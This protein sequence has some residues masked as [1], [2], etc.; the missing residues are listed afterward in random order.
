MTLHDGHLCEHGFIQANSALRDGHL[1]ELG[2]IQANSALHDGHL[3]EL[4]LYKPTVPAGN[5][6]LEKPTSSLQSPPKKSKVAK[7]QQTSF[8]ISLISS[9]CVFGPMCVIAIHNHII[10]LI[11]NSWQTLISQSH[12]TGCAT[13]KLKVDSI[14]TMC[15][16]C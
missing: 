5:K 6:W 13:V 15:S 8:M 14:G 16:P 7:F 3:C 2:F 9:V 11:A 10:K 4:G 1:C 12:I